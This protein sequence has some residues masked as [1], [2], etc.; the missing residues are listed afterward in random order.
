MAYIYRVSKSKSYRK[1]VMKHWQTNIKLL[2]LTTTAIWVDE[3]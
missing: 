1:P 2:N 3:K